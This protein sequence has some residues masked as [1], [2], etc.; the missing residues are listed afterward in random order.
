MLRNEGVNGGPDSCPW[1]TFFAQILIQFKQ[2][3]KGGNIE[4]ME[5]P[6]DSALLKF[7][8]ALNLKEFLQISEVRI[9]Y[10]RVIWSLAEEGKYG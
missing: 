2:T 5:E 1:G 10:K 9:I 3:V 6:G 7:F 4:N 8:N